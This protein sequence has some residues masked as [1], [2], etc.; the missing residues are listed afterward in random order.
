MDN[1]APEKDGNRV[2][3]V[4][5]YCSELTDKPMNHL[6][7]TRTGCYQAVLADEKE[8]KDVKKMMREITYEFTK[9]QVISEAVLESV[10]A[11]VGPAESDKAM[12]LICKRVGIFV[13]NND[14]DHEDTLSAN[15]SDSS[16]TSSSPPSES[17]SDHEEQVSF[18]ALWICHIWICCL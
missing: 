2:S 9:R 13:R 12:R 7:S 14:T 3:S 10:I 6:K 5:P 18:S 11:K 15:D 1:E 8:P 17:E 16:E 4:C